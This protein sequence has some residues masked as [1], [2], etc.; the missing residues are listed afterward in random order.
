[1]LKNI[2]LKTKILL[3]TFIILLMSLCFIVFDC[4][5]YI[6]AIKHKKSVIK[7]VEK[8]FSK[9]KTI[10]YSDFSFSENVDTADIK[11]LSAIY[12]D[13]KT[14]FDE[15]SVTQK[16]DYI[17]KIIFE[18]GNIKE[19]DT[20]IDL[21]S[22]LGIDCLLLRQI[23]IGDKGKVIG[24]DIKELWNVVSRKYCE[25]LGYNNVDFILGDI[26]ELPLDNNIADVVI[27][28]YT[29]TLISEKEK[30]FSEIYR[31]LKDGG[32]CYIGDA[33]IWGDN[34]D[35]LEEIKNDTLYADYYINRSIRE[36][37]YLR[38]LERIGFK[39]IKIKITNYE[40]INDE[41]YVVNVSNT[42]KFRNK[43]TSAGVYIYAEKVKIT[44]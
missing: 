32:S 40:M 19:G 15:W 17:S 37:E 39:N 11:Y 22:G 3:I 6:A 10:N 35:L 2:K 43:I 13:I 41:G 23:I 8:M 12:D 16:T 30:V 25:Y 24:I 36:E 21:G 7:E 38:I 33:I 42:G 5:K 9:L 34:F 4:N 29:L 14:N 27:S 44:N 20:V 31:I 1:M 18:I 26:R 28:N